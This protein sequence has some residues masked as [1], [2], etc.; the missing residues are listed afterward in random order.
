MC[1]SGEKQEVETYLSECSKFRIEPDASVLVTLST[2]WQVLA[3]SFHFGEGKLLPLLKVLSMESCCVRRLVLRTSD[4]YG[5]DR[6]WSGEGVSCDARVLSR[7]LA[8]NES[9][10]EVDLASCGL[11]DLGVAELAAALQESKV[12]RLDLR[13]NAFGS[14][15]CLALTEAVSRGAAAGTCALKHLDVEMNGLGHKTVSLLRSG[16]PPAICLK[17]EDGNFTTEELLNSL[18]HGAGAV[19]ALVGSVP[20]LNDALT[21]DRATFWMCFVYSFTLVFCFASSSAFHA[22]FRLPTAFKYLQR[23][24]H[25]AIYLL[26]AGSYMPFLGIGMRDHMGATIIL[27]LVWISG[28]IGSLCSAAGVGLTMKDIN[29]FEVFVYAVMGLAVVPIITDVKDTFPHEAFVLLVLGGASYLLGIIFFVGGAKNPFL[30]VIWHFFVLSG[31]FLHWFAVYLYLIPKAE[32]EKGTH[33][34]VNT[35]NVRSQLID[36][37]HALASLASNAFASVLQ[38]RNLTQSVVPAHLIPSIVAAFTSSQATH[39][40]HQVEPN[41]DADTLPTA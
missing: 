15:G 16:L 18:T 14:E 33:H 32:I 8:R 23:A 7:V 29:P 31:A 35:D 3:P 38:D 20:L 17:I 1:Q 12:V 10:E 9:M 30:H 5:A 4:E 11:R 40:R 39:H 34:F 28:S 41:A 37:Q 27:V 13:R 36:V 24:D 19:L 2:R 6:T 25:A 26:I 21:I 22:C